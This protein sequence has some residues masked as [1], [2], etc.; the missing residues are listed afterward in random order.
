MIAPYDPQLA[1]AA[2]WPGPRDG[3]PPRPVNVLHLV[4]DEKFIPFVAATFNSC[5][6]ALNSFLVRVASAS[7]SLRFIRDLPNMRLVQTEYFA[8]EGM[9]ADLNS[10][11]CLIL[12]CMTPSGFAM[13]AKAPRR[14]AVVWSGWG[15]DYHALFPHGP[16]VLLE[17]HTKRLVSAMRPPPPGT[18]WMRPMRKLRQLSAERATK[19]RMTEGLGRVDFFSAP[20]PDDYPMVKKMLGRRFRAQYAQIN[21][22][23]LERT[24]A[25]GT[26]DASGDNV[27][28]GNSAYAT[29]NHVD[30]FRALAKLDLGDRRIICPLS[31]GDAKYRH[32]VVRYG[33]QLFGPDRFVA[34][35]D[36]V[37]LHEYNALVSSCGTAFMCHRRQQALG[38]V[39]TLLYAGA[40]V[41]LNERSTLYG[42][43]RRSGA[44]V[45]GF[46]EIA[47][48]SQSVFT[49]LTP[50]QKAENRNVLA[51]FWSD[52]VVRGNVE[53]LLDAVVQRRRQLAS[54]QLRHEELAHPKAQ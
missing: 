42:F 32:E 11:D 4:H 28:V 15:A 8:S 33:I 41:F 20:I 45:C 16:E 12:H 51:A 31:Y 37:P 29:N 23:S 52:E 10:C 30:V 2:P 50:H 22:A 14:V 43:L 24:F 40:K 9:L 48:S 36:F 18:V 44:F 21:Y 1:P 35:V 27:L 25:L 38:N 39:C 7:A 34:L 26:S 3:N 47:R 49:P 53:Q 19:R 46:L 54:D 6:G 5:P 13:L 17:R